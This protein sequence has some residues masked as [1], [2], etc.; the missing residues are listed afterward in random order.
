MAY[1]NMMSQDSDTQESLLEEVKRWKSTKMVFKYKPTTPDTMNYVYYSPWKEIQPTVKILR[2]ER[3]EVQNKTFDEG[4]YLKTEPAANISA[5]D[6]SEY[7]FRV[8][9][10]KARVSSFR[11]T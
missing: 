9:N 8:K 1:Q 6:L 4:T 10:T 2:K 7:R 3:E 5:A 11:K